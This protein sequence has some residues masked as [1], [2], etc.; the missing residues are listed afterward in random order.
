M[1]FMRKIKDR[2]YVSLKL[3][4]GRQKTI[5]LKTTNER[6]AKQRLRK[7]QEMEVLV[8]SKIMDEMELLE[9]LQLEGIESL[10]LVSL[11]KRY[12][13]YC[14][15]RVKPSTKDMYRLAFIDLQVIFGEYFASRH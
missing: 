10:S 2:Y 8:K 13:K 11:T 15:N 5:S 9:T 1:A 3:R 4:N 14:G 6:Y 12:L 7:I